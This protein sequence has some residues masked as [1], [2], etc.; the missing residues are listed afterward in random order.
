MASGYNT[1][2]TVIWADISEVS[3]RLDKD[4][5]ELVLF[6]LGAPPVLRSSMETCW[7]IAALIEF[8]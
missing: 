3:E 8:V 1:G 4:A 7:I 2:P 5:V 6:Y